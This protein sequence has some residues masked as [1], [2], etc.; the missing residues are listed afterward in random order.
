MTTTNQIPAYVSF[1][2]QLKSKLE[3]AGVP[4]LVTDG[5]DTGLPENKGWVRFESS[6]NGHK[7]YVPKSEL[8]MGMAETTLPVLHR[9]GARPMAKVNGKIVCKVLPDVDLL[10]D[11]MVDLFAEAGEKLPANRLPERK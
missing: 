4:I 2:A 7:V 10:A 5:T 6:V 3:D 11:L 1:C 9:N 8:R